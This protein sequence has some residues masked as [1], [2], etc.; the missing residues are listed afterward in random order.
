VLP[1][2]AQYLA[3][4]GPPFLAAALLVVTWRYTRHTRR[5]VDEMAESR[6]ASVRPVLV[7]M[8]EFSSVFGDRGQ[9]HWGVKN[10]GFGPALDVDVSV[11]YEP[12][13]TGFRLKRAVIERGDARWVS[14]RDDTIKPDYLSLDVIAQDHPTLYLRGSY[15]DV[16][17]HT[18]DAAMMMPFRD[19][20]EFVVPKELEG[21]TLRDIL[22]PPR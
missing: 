18:H 13:E 15:R 2:W 22:G 5:M 17:G 8:M 21:K 4:L 16:L 9:G 1:F 19:R 10:V 6:K 11:S 3:A 14:T 12:G 7:P 20:W